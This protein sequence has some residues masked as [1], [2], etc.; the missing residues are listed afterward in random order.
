MWLMLVVKHITLEVIFFLAFLYRVEIM[1]FSHLLV[2]V[3]N[4]FK[5]SGLSIHLFVLHSSF[6]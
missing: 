4:F 2:E 3:H 6:E 5:Y 1:A